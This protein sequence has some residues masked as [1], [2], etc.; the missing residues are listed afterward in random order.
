[1]GA[2]ESVIEDD[3]NASDPIPSRSL[4]NSVNKTMQPKKRR[5]PSQVKSIKRMEGVVLGCPKTGKRT[6]LRRLEG[7]DPFT[8]SNK[9]KE[10]ENDKDRDNPTELSCPSIMI[11]YKPPLG[12]TT[13][14]RVK[15]RIQ[16]AKN[17]EKIQNKIDFVVVLINSK[18][19]RDTTQ[20]YLKHVLNFYLDLLGHLSDTESDK[21]RERMRLSSSS[22]SSSSESNSKTSSIT[23]ITEPFCMVI[24][25]NFRDLQDEGKDEVVSPV[26]K[27]LEHLVRETLRSRNVPEGD[28]VIDLLET[29]LRN[30]YGLDGLHRFIYRAYLQRSR[31]DLEKQ[32]DIV[33]NKIQDT[34]LANTKP[35]IYDEFIKEIIPKEKTKPQRLSDAT[36]EQ[37]R[38]SF[39]NLHLKPN[40]QKGQTSSDRM[41][42]KALEDFLASSDE[43]DETPITKAN[44]AKSS[45]NFVAASSS[46]S[47]DEDD[48]FFYDE[49][50]DRRRNENKKPIGYTNGDS[51]NDEEKAQS[52]PT[53][54][55]SQQ[56]KSHISSPI[57]GN[58]GRDRNLT[59]SVE[60]SKSKPNIN[61]SEKIQKTYADENT[62]D[63]EDEGD[64]NE[65]ANETKKYL[66][67]SEAATNDDISNERTKESHIQKIKDIAEDQKEIETLIVL[68]KEEEIHVA[69]SETSKCTDE[70]Q[71][72]KTSDNLQNIQAT[73][74]GVDEEEAFAASVVDV[75]D[76]DDAED[77]NCQN[78]NHDAVDFKP[79]LD[80]HDNDHDT[81]VDKKALMIDSVHVEQKLDNDDDGDDDYII[82]ST[83]ANTATEKDDDN[84]FI[85]NSMSVEEKLDEGDS[86]DDDFMICSKDVDAEIEEDNRIENT[87]EPLPK[88]KFPIN[89]SIQ[90]KSSV[91]TKSNTVSILH[92]DDNKDEE[93]QL[94][95]EDFTVERS[96]TASKTVASSASMSEAALA[97]I[98]AAQKEAEAMLQQLQQQQ[99]VNTAVHIP[100]IKEEKY[101]KKKKKNEKDEKKKKKKKK[102]KKI[103][104]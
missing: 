83:N 100:L 52:I 27:N 13:W 104:S 3:L 71:K 22:S 58:T 96:V 35:M 78:D 88:T 39:R 69:A 97:A 1:M 34:N 45:K 32:L 36:T 20:S 15:L 99:P 37:N 57:D 85:I 2:T 67:R 51:Y 8:I 48:D 55:T 72:K 66:Q 75:D 54:T 28:I 68:E 46:S 43:E 79:Q 47:D 49:S 25:L 63:I 44:A 31:V 24:L 16:Y 80:D 5:P 103:D 40:R 23:N 41:G 81:V 4:P 26:I 64:H 59:I 29:S 14:D 76:T 73:K 93:P 7:V 70:E 61:V 101:K 65:E 89:D 17:F 98:A 90:K 33:R 102:K 10:D 6:L 91:E 87:V 62:A 95:D 53:P 50:G 84:N 30:C 11:P 86:D 94:E 21:E 77:I 12:S 9:S 56:L 18:H 19:P 38:N 92:S 82:G 42:K 74:N 60:R